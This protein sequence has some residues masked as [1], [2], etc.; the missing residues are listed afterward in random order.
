MANPSKDK[1][2]RAETAV[3]R[4]LQGTGWPSAERRASNGAADRGDI[5]GTPYICWEVKYRDKM[6]GDGQ[7]GLWLIETDTER[8]NAKADLG[9]LV[10]RRPRSS[11][12]DWW[13]IV[14][15][16]ALALIAEGLAFPGQGPMWPARMALRDLVELLRAA[17]Y[18]NPLEVPRGDV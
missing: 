12:E 10:V 6:P 5:T 11:V 7:I 14:P 4:Y 18:G 2:T 17:G 13:A 1:G 16:W 15:F 8:E 9:I 3:V